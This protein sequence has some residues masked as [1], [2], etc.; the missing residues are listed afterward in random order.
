[1]VY[2][3]LFMFTF[4]MIAGFAAAKFLTGRVPEIKNE[5]FHLH[6]WIWATMILAGLVFWEGTQVWMI[7]LMAGTAIEGL[8]YDEWS[9]FTKRT[10]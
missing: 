5:T 2:D 6:H 8:T 1:M 7:G 4:S 10:D 9:L 3:D